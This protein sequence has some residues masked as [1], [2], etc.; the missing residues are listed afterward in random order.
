MKINSYQNDPSKSY[1]IKIEPFD[2][3][4]PEE[5]GLSYKSQ[6]KERAVISYS[7]IVQIECGMIMCNIK[8]PFI[9]SKKKKWKN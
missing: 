6:F 3:I 1:F 7:K 8:F 2:D 9:K 4:N 5:L